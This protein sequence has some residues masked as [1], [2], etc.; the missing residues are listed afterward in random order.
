MYPLVI[1]SIQRTLITYR[2]YTIQ[3]FHVLMK[4][5]MIKFFTKVLLPKLKME[6]RFKQKTCFNI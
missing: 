6:I 3:V 1:D 5:Q 4:K 2:Q